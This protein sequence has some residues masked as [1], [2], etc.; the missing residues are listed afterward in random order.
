M[1]V[2]DTN[3][4]VWSASM[5]DPFGAWWRHCAVCA[6]GYRTNGATSPGD[7]PLWQDALPGLETPAACG[8]CSLDHRERTRLQRCNESRK[9]N[10]TPNLMFAPEVVSMKLCVHIGPWGW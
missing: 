2:T 4:E 3:V 7:F 5:L 9:S 1:S 8:H 10:A 6:T